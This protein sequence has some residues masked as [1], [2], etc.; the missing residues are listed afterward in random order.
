P[1]EPPWPF[2]PP[3]LEPSCPFEPPPFE[4]CPLEPSCPLEPPPFE[5]PEPLLWTVMPHGAIRC[6]STSI[7]RY[8]CLIDCHLLSKI[9]L[10]G[11]VTLGAGNTKTRRCALPWL[12]T[13]PRL[14]NSHRL[15][16]EMLSV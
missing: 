14:C 1:F 8:R 5:P 6:S 12:P 4:P 7:S 9:W 11:G 10:P 3:P 2:E 13:A 16:D 15:Q